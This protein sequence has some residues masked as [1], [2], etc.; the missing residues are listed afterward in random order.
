M[1]KKVIMPTALFPNCVAVSEKRR[2]S[3][4]MRKLKG[5]K[6]PVK[7]LN[8]KASNNHRCEIWKLGLYSSTEIECGRLERKLANLPIGILANPLNAIK[9]NG[10]DI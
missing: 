9:T 10:Y 3:C 7:L 8:V 6:G 4:P 1:I 5:V 2:T